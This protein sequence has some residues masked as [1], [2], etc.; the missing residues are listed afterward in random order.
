MTV[1]FWE[2]RRCEYEKSVPAE[3]LGNRLMAAETTKAE[4]LAEPIQLGIRTEVV[5]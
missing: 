3:E 1:P 5:P 2:P 4:I